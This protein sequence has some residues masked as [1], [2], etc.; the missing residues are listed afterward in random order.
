[1]QI[2][3]S[4]VINLVNNM[5][6]HANIM[7]NRVSKML[8]HIRNMLIYANIMLIHVDNMLIHVNI[9]TTISG[10]QTFLSVCEST[11]LFSTAK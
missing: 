6:K 8:I 11:S 1:M 9:R 3:D 4:N 10:L 5:L 2:H 7:V